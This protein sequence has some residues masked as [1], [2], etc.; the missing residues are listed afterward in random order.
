MV[1]SADCI[2]PPGLQEKIGKE[3]L[4][5]SSA[6]AVSDLCLWISIVQ[7]IFP[8]L[9]VGLAAILTEMKKRFQTADIP[10]C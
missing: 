6:S 2:P 9:Q 3:H 4:Q 5:I 8:A 10:D 7:G 1:H